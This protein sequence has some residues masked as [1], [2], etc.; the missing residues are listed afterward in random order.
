MFL[1]CEKYR[2]FVLEFLLA[3]PVTHFLSQ[4]RPL[5][6]KGI[7]DMNNDTEQTQNGEYHMQCSRFDG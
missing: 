7:S 6:L 5:R 2:I 1:I 3:L 4:L